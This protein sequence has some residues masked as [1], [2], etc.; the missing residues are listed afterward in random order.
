MD[1]LE[2]RT[3]RDKKS[4]RPVV[5]QGGRWVYADTAKLTED[6]GKAQGYA[7][8]M[9]DAEQ[10]YQRAVERGYDP[11]GFKNAAASI[12]EGLPFGGLDGIGALIRDDTGDL[13]RQAE[14]QFSDAQLK[15]MSGAAAPE[16][17]VKRGVK[18]FFPRPGENAEVIG[19]EKYMARQQ[20]F[21]A[22]RRRAGPAAAEVRAPAFAG[23]GQPDP[24]PK[25]KIDDLPK[26]ALTAYRSRFEGGMIDLQQPRGSQANPYL[27]RSMQQAE[28][29]PQGSYVILP[30]G[31]FGVVD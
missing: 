8:L 5:R 7:R 18:T 15:A 19:P 10:R 12:A 13:A 24:P 20:A 25:P 9:A 27:A 2:G 4:G 17:E 6:Q 30:D 23:D 11:S 1:P 26:G 29:L 14:L 3:G 21:E 22:A 16:A 31:S 28:T